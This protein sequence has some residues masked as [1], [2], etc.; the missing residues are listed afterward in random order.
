MAKRAALAIGVC[1]RLDVSVLRRAALAFALT[2][3]PAAARATPGPDTTVVIANANVP[4][5]V[6]LAER[7]AAARDVPDAQVCLLDVEDVEDVDL[8]TYEAA[9]LGPLR[10][11][12]D[13]TPGVRDRIEAALLIRGLPLRVRVPVG[14]RDR[15]VS[16]AAALSLWNS[17][18]MGAPLLGAEPGRVADCG[19]TPCYAATWDNPYSGFA[20]EPGY[21]VERGGVT[22][23]PI[24]VTMLHGRSY[25]DAESLLDSALMA[26]ATDP[27]PGELLFMEGSDAARGALDVEYDRVILEL[28]ELGFTASRVGFDADLTGRTLSGFATGTARLG[29]TIEGNTFR[30]GSLVDNL[31]SFG[32]VPEN[33]RASGEERQVS[34]AR[35]VAQGVAGAHGTVAEPLN[36]CFPRRWLFV[37][38]ALGATLAES[39][40]AM[41]PYAY[42]LNLVLGDPMAAPYAR[43]PVVEVNGVTDGDVIDAPTPLTVTAVDPAARG[44]ESIALYLDGEELRRVDGDEVSLCLG[45]GAAA[46]QLLVVARAADDPMGVRIWKPKGWTAMTVST[47][48]EVTCP[49]PGADAGTPDAGATAGDGGAD[50]GPGAPPMDEGCACRA[51]PPSGAAPGWLLVA[52]LAVGCRRRRVTG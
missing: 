32:A 17:E 12:L 29:E 24:L 4:Q 11:C 49:D 46:R 41:L 8:A 15:P 23:R 16:L 13:A 28:T 51:A 1:L 7:Y 52:A 21:E 43:R 6:A 40:W 31:T 25:E 30:P 44:V 33:F 5:S 9:V 34:I 20:F 37:E 36:N 45:P 2:L 26:E 19:G 10:D 47:D 42:W 18:R 22:W 38:Y 3:L 35:W 27:P 48:G 14:G 39:Y 50:A